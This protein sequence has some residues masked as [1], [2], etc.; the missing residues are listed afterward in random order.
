MVRPLLERRLLTPEQAQ[1]VVRESLAIVA[2]KIRTQA[3]RLAVRV[4][5]AD[6]EHARLAR[7]RIAHWYRSISVDGV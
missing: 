3:A 5:P 6:P 4:N 2:S 1:E 7:D